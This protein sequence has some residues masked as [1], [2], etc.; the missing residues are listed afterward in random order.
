[1]PL[2]W[3]VIQKSRLNKSNEC[4]ICS[5][6]VSDIDLREHFNNC[7]NKSIEI[8]F[9]KF[10]NEISEIKLFYENKIK[11]FKKYTNLSELCEKCEFF[12]K[13]D[14]IEIEEL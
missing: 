1:M 14:T 5:V 9:Y 2:H 13:Q 8:L 12:S 10:D 4:K 6:F 7:Y 11:Q 3:T